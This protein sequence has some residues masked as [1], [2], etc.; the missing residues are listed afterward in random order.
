MAV[1]SHDVHTNGQWEELEFCIKTAHLNLLLVMFVKLCS[2]MLGRK[3]S[4]STKVYRKRSQRI[5]RLKCKIAPKL[6]A[7]IVFFFI[8]FVT[9]CI[10]P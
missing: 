9:I 5:Q 3:C 1:T 8:F 4:V 2:I 6:G 7:E 10:G